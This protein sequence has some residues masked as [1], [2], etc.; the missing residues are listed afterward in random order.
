M[1]ALARLLTRVAKRVLANNPTNDE[2]L[3]TVDR[4]VNWR[5][6]DYINDEQ[7]D[8]IASAIQEP[9][10]PFASVDETEPEEMSTPTDTAPEIEPEQ[11]ETD[12][13]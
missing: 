3:S 4:V 5:N 1:S 6:A 10:E 7:V 2:M 12:G 11:P 9:S 8:E 13:E